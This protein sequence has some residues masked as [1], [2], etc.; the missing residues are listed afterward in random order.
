MAEKKKLAKAEEVEVNENATVAQELTITEK[1]ENA[2]ERIEASG[3][4]SD[5]VREEQKKV[6]KE[7]EKTAKQRSQEAKKEQLEREKNAKAVAERK[8]AEFS[9]A[10][11]YRKKL[12]K[13]SK[14]YISPSKQRELDRKAAEAARLEE[15]RQNELAE[16]LENER[17]IAEERT[18]RQAELL[19]K[20]RRAR[21]ERAEDSKPVQEAEKPSEAEAIPANEAEAM[22]ANEAEAMP[23]NVAEDIPANETEAMPKAEE[24]VREKPVIEDTAY[25]D[26]F[27]AKKKAEDED[28]KLS[29]GV[30]ISEDGKLKKS[31]D[32]EDDVENMT[33]RIPHRTPKYIEPKAEDKK[34]SSANIN[35]QT[36]DDAQEGVT[37]DL[38]SYQ[39]DM[40]ADMYMPAA[41]NKESSAL[42]KQY[43]DSLAAFSELMASYD[44]ELAALRAQREGKGAEN[45]D[46]ADNAE[47]EKAD[48]PISQPEAVA[49]EEASQM[50][51]EPVTAD[52]FTNTYD[53]E[54]LLRD[55]ENMNRKKLPAY[56]EK[57]HKKLEKLARCAKRLEK[58]IN[59]VE[60]NTKLEYLLR[61]LS[62]YKEIIDLLCENLKCCAL[63]GVKKYNS[64]F[65]KR[66]DKASAKYNALVEKYESVTG[67][68]L[69]RAKAGV[70]QDI[71]DG[72]MYEPLPT[73]TYAKEFGEQEPT[74]ELAEQLPEGD[75]KVAREITE[76]EQKLTKRISILV[77]QK[78]SAKITSERA[79]LLAECI[80]AERDLVELTSAKL[81]SAVADDNKKEINNYR[82]KLNLAVSEYNAFIDE[83]EAATGLSITK[84]KDTL[85]DSI[86]EGKS[87]EPLPEISY[88][89]HKVSE[90]DVPVVTK[91]ELREI[92]E[93][94]K[95]GEIM[96]DTQKKLSRYL[97]VN[98]K[99]LDNI[100]KRIKENEKKKKTKLSA[101]EYNRTILNGIL[102]IGN[103]MR[104]SRDCLIA[105]YRLGAGKQI[106]AWGKQLTVAV[107]AYNQE[108]G[109]YYT[110]TGVKLIKV[111]PTIADDIVGG[112][113]YQ[114][115]PTIT[116]RERFVELDDGEN[117]AVDS[118]VFVFP[119]PDEIAQT[120]TLSA[121]TYVYDVNIREEALV[122]DMIVECPV[123]VDKFFRKLKIKRRRSLSKFETRLKG[124]DFELR[125]E[126]N[127]TDKQIMESE[128]FT[129][130][131]LIVKKIVILK[132]LTELRCQAL[133]YSCNFKDKKRI[134]RYK[135]EII[136][137]MFEYNAAI[138]E[139]I[140]ESGEVLSPASAF[141]PYDIISGKEYSGLPTI[142]FRREFVETN[143]DSVRVLES[144]KR[145]AE[146]APSQSNGRS[147]NRDF[148]G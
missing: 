101:D 141:I 65:V 48:E 16:M 32:Y 25:A 28:M 50:Q 87:Y 69:T 14:R 148:F 137:A 120:Q 136:S 81:A 1:L 60:G 61:C 71:I 72:K 19:D 52:N 73:V 100:N 7:S 9:Y 53:T 42:N 128:G 37:P 129:K 124:A 35:G 86:V 123:R 12:I 105:S 24:P 55:I 20:I 139:Y 13:D 121:D 114:T 5:A 3:A 96:P 144:L 110:A 78:N 143:G 122:S 59:K 89:K 135:N 23:A 15:Q 79:R 107:N 127:N 90:F 43:K 2:R 18:A 21:A 130:V 99:R 94:E 51:S 146:G 63:L 40:F 102:L 126:L 97:S 49:E 27:K 76:S 22:P 6:L 44:R 11:N 74:V 93:K 58:K 117:T 4:A 62:V 82:K 140:N 115:L 46:N 147:E 33:L 104:I 134:A 112:R 66:I 67:D 47:Q 98:A 85:A 17:R 116:V 119:R 80:M 29:F 91:R 31:E 26:I 88:R 57:S 92:R 111:S 118:A 77:K 41:D 68:T 36:A 56:L 39:Y 84:A 131:K 142:A 108:V 70:G 10:E 30:E 45:T 138:E 8:L 133:A 54:L 75:V 34:E 113:S 145:S 106:S 95:R 132:K 83:Y 64:S 38:E 109:N 103:A 125:R